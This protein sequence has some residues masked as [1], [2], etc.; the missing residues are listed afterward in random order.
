MSGPRPEEAIVAGR[1]LM[2][3][4]AGAGALEHAARSAAAMARESGGVVRIAWMYPVPPPRVDRDERVV[5][6]TDREMARLAERAHERMSALA[7]EFGEIPVER[8]VRFGRLATELA[9]EAHVWRADLVG[10]A[11]SAARPRPPPPRVVPGA[12][13]HGAARAAPDPAARWRRPPPRA[14][15]APRVSLT[16][17]RGKASPVDPPQAESGYGATGRAIRSCF[18]RFSCRFSRGPRVA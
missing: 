7:W 10:L 18:R 15:R 9:V 12:D 11:V 16:R 8:V 2:V 1:V 5:A 6:D 13:G 4:S 14:H 3:I 17:E